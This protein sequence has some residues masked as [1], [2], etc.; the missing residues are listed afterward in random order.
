MQAMQDLEAEMARAEKAL[1]KSQEVRRKQGD[2]PY[3]E[4]KPE[5]NRHE[6]RKREAIARRKE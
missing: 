4:C 3:N 6:R 2:A 5:C 1:T